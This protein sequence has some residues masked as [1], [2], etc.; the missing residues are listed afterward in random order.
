MEPQFTAS[1]PFRKIAF[2]LLAVLKCGGSF[3]SQREIFQEMFSCGRSLWFLSFNL[4]F[5]Y[6]YY[7]SPLGEDF[8]SPAYTNDA[9]QVYNFSFSH[10]NSNNRGPRT[11]IIQANTVP[12][13]F[14]SEPCLT[15]EAGARFRDAVADY[16]RLSK[17]SWTLKRQFQIEQ[18]YE[19]V[20]SDT[21]NA[22]FQQRARDA[23]YKRFPSSFGYSVFSAVG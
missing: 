17:K 1:V 18:P 3:Y 11:L 22:L 7:P 9:Y 23:F 8:S 10:N 21:L 16:K 13:M 12:D 15:S 4:W 6:F 20:N 2:T 19:P 14:N 5:L